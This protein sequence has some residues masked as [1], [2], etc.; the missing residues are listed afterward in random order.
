MGGAWK[1]QEGESLS[2]QFVGY[3]E[4]VM[5]GP[6]TSAQVQEFHQKLTELVQIAQGGRTKRKIRLKRDPSLELT[7]P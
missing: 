4:I 2:N 7:Q 3:V 6:M 1:T 5:D